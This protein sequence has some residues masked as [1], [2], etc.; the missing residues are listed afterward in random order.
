MIIYILCFLFSVFIAA[1]SQVLLK[2]EAL[3]PHQSVVSE[4]LNPM[5]VGA[6]FLFF[7]T[8]VIEVIAYR[9]IPL[10]LGPVLETTSYFYV[11]LFG[12]LVFK[13]KL[14]RKKIAALILIIIGILIYSFS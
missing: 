6:Y 8:T 11:T 4:Y 7:M 12:V 10:S 1:V 13:E 14:T 3:K 9:G 2:K 5:V